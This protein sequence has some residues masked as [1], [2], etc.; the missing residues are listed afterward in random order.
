MVAFQKGKLSIKNGE[1][2]K[3][4]KKKSTNQSQ[5]DWKKVMP[6]HNRG[7]EKV[8][9]GKKYYWCGA[10]TKDGP[11]PSWGDHL[12]KDCP[13]KPVFTFQ[14]NKKKN[15]KEKKKEEKKEGMLALANAVDD[16]SS[17]ES[18]NSVEIKASYAFSE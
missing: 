13:H 11:C 17:D 1:K 8:V 10:H 6:D 12:R 14:K 15:D 3:Q 5:T 7:K 9:D 2:T 16:S 4:E 18:L